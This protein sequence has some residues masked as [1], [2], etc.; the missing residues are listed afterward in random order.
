[1]AKIWSNQPNSPDKF[2]LFLVTTAPGVYFSIMTN[3]SGF[4]FHELFE[5]L[6]RISHGDHMRQMEYL[7]VENEILRSKCPKRITTTADEKYRLLQYG[8]PLGGKLKKFI[9]IVHY[10]TFRRWATNDGA[11]GDK[12]DRRGR[13]RITSKEMVDLILRM[14]KENLGWGYPRIRAELQKLYKYI[15]ARNTVKAI[16]IRHGIPPAPKRNLD[17]WDAYIKRTFETLWACDFFT[18]TV[19]TAMGPRV[20][21]VLFFINIRTRKVHIAGI[22]KNPNKEWIEDI[23]KTLGF[24]SSEFSGTGLRRKVLIR[25]GDTKF[26]KEFDRIIQA[27]GIEIK[28]IPYRSPN[29]NPYAE[30]WVGTVKKECLNYFVAFGVAH[31]EYLVREYVQY[32]NTMRPHSGLKDRPIIETEINF[33]GEVQCKSLLGGLVKNF[34][35]VESAPSG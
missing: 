3:G 24:L 33:S 10:A 17:T 4:L 28:R 25:D 18:K 27:S 14:A 16:L 26:T 19:W 1:M 34:S 20:F 22:T 15:P 23:A 7:K 11:R 13:P 32:Y 30:S 12:K 29:L 35:R 8:L 9:S 5:L 6:G 2:S 31:F 21:Y